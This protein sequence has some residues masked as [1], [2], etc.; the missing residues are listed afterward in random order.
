MSAAYDHYAM[1]NPYDPATRG[2]RMRRN[3]PAI[4]CAVIGL[5]LAL[6]VS[7]LIAYELLRGPDIEAYAD[8]AI[9]IE[10][11]TEESFTITPAELAS[12][13]CVHYSIT[14]EGSGD[15]GESKA[16]TVDAYGPTLDTFLAQ[17]GCEI[18]DFRRVAVFCKDG[19]DVYLQGEDL[20]GEIILSIALG[21]DALKETH[22]PLRVVAVELATGYWAYGVERIQ[23]IE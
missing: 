22:Q 14:G 8:A 1:L 21:K 4:V 9:E 3:A 16:G 15:N 20:E 19:Y 17:Y 11:L 10:G 2:A 13:D 7:G 5:L 6:V 18:G 12:L 23:F